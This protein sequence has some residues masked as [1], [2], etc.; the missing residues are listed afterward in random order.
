M[1]PNYNLIFGIILLIIYYFASM[2]E[3]HMLPNYAQIFEGFKN[4]WLEDELL[5]HFFRSIFLFFRGALFALIISLGLVYI[6]PLK[7]LRPL[8]TFA[9]KCRYLPLV[10]FTYYASLMFDSARSV[11]Y[12]MLTFFI[13]TFFITSLLSMVDDISEDE[14]NHAKT[15]GLTK[16]EQ[17]KELIVFGRI[18]YVIDIFRQNIAISFVMMVAIE[19]IMFGNGGLGTLLKTANKWDGQGAIIALQIIILCIGTNLDW[20]LNTIRKTFFRYTF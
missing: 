18:D 9:S 3:T 4:L 17:I 15:L 2:G 10:G 16:W 19:M 11:Q 20:F 6:S 14:W 7:W 12:F 13:S 1:K 8:S 5:Y